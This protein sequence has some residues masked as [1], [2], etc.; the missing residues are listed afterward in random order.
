MRWAPPPRWSR[1]RKFLPN[2]STLLCRN[3][4]YNM[5]YADLHC[6]TLTQHAHLR[7]ANG[8]HNLST[9]QSVG[10]RLLCCAAYLPYVEGNLYPK[11]LALA[12]KLQ[13]ELD[14]NADIAMPVL[15]AADALAAERCGKVGV[16]FTAEEGGI[17]EED[18]AHLVALHAKG[19][20]MMT[21]T[22]NY[23]NRLGYPNCNANLYTTL[24]RDAIYMTDDRPL[25]PLGHAVLAEMNRLGVIAD[26]S[27]LS[28][29]GF[30]DVVRHSTQPVVA[31]HSNAR[32][33][34]RVSRNLTDD[35]LVALAQKGGVCGLNFCPDFLAD[36]DEDLL[37]A[38]KRHVAHIWQV[39]GEDVLAVGTDFDGITPREPLD[40]CRSL[41]LLRQT[42]LDILPPRVVDKMMWGNVL[43]VV[44]EVCG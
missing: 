15:C 3:V 41:P 36:K 1:L 17:V 13:R 37:D 34:T 40:S 2:F 7:T 9:L 44:A 29:G 11:A 32:A 28:D 38:A 5:I 35:M 33:V 12:D 10:C 24:G 6:D 8:P 14:A 23:P 18:L 4:Y 16:M 42:L 22:W 21:F 43:R 31:S 20:R 26:V 25:T 27:H 39:A 19:L 30:W